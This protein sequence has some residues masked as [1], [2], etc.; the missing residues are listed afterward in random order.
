MAPSSL[1]DRRSLLASTAA[2][3][4]AAATASAAPL[5][6]RADESAEAGSAPA[7]SAAPAAP[8][9]TV[10]VA[11]ATGQTGRRVVRQLRAE[12][13]NVIA[14]VRDVG[15]AQS[16]GFALD[17]SGLRIAQADVVKQSSE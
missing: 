2:A 13:F 12:G 10:F 4:A 3:L 6:A 16:L 9:N 5:P 11:G 8:I 7:A 1:L 15:K 14:G 17:A